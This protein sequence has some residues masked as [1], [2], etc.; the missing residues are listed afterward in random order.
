MEQASKAFRQLYR[1]TIQFT[2]MLHS[3]QNIYY[4]NSRVIELLIVA[5]IWYLAVVTLLQIGQY[6][7][8]KRFARGRDGRARRPGKAPA[9]S[10]EGGA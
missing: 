8:E 3:A 6:F 7:L 2:E 4:A 5:A 9:V 1:L 10:V